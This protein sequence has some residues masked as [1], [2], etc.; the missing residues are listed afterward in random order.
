[1]RWSKR[2]KILRISK[3]VI[4]IA[5]AV[6]LLFAG[7]A[8]FAREAENFVVH[9]SQPTDVSLLLDYDVNFTDPTTHLIVPV[10]GRYEDVTYTPNPRLNYDDV[11]YGTN[12]PD[13]IAQ[14]EGVHSVYEDKNRLAFFSFSFYLK[15]AS[16]RA[17]DI[18]MEL[19]VDEVVVESKTS[20]HHI[21]GAV[22]IMFIEEKPL[23]SE[24]AYTVYKLPEATEE[25]ETDPQGLGMVSYGNVLP[26]ESDNIVLSRKGEMGYKSVSAGEIKRFTIVIWLEGWDPD[27]IDE[28]RYDSMKMSLNFKGY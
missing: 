3:V 21:D 8:V 24:N 26:F 6:S 27:C 4:P 7:F 23:L 25:E 11:V 9:V 16:E 19:T 12:L 28:V 14:K 13:D 2:L 5:L 22:R 1:M 10:G 15:N 18:D 20:T 17:V